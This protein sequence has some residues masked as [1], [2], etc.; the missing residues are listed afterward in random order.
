M[1]CDG[2]QTAIRQPS[3][4]PKPTTANRRQ[5]PTNPQKAPYGF[6]DRFYD[7]KPVESIKLYVRRVFISDEVDD[8]I[9]K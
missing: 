7:K 1:G 9:P 8:L 2:R 6:F 4:S 3:S 5:P